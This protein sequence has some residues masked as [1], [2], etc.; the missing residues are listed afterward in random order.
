M[1]IYSR[2]GYVCIN[3]HR[4]AIKMIQFS[5]VV[6]TYHG[7]SAINLYEALKSIVDQSLP[8]SELIVVAD[9]PVPDDQ[10]DVI[11]KIQ[12]EAGFVVNLILM[13]TNQGR[14]VARNI[15]ID[16]A[17]YEYVALMDSDDICTLDRFEKQMR[18][19]EKAPQI[20]LIA[21]VTEEFFDGPKEK[22]DSAV[23]KTCPCS[24][25]DIARALQWSNCVA[26]PTIIFKKSAW[27]EVG[28]FPPYR[29]INEDY[30]FYLR[31]IAEGV[32][33]HCVPDIVL[34]VRIS[35]AQ[36]A[37][38]RGFSILKSD[39]V[40]RLAAFRAGYI[41]FLPTVAILPLLILRRLA[42]PSMGAWLQIGW[43]HIAKHIH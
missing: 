32:I 3:E 36:R 12:N 20:G 14:G 38:R 10:L 22:S 26:N 33:F 34:R 24:H 11:K 15:G 29:D 21:G 19:L 37:R 23:I 43:R 7:E 4:T 42:P 39:F 30:L 6:S 2:S 5:V 35:D 17:Q 16:A 1:G 13:P 25:N 41:G 40:F 28:G 31:L 18:V 9:G 27:R 8:P